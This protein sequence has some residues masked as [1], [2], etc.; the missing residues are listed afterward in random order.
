MSDDDLLKTARALQGLAATAVDDALLGK[1]V[2]QL[3]AGQGAALL[4]PQER[5][6]VHLKVRLSDG[7]PTNITVPKALL[8]SAAQRLGGEREARQRVRS[9]AKRA[10]PTNNRSGWVQDELARSLAAEAAR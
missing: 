1:A 9:L 4:E 8:H 6:V 7:K 5:S 10:P 3:L 2:R